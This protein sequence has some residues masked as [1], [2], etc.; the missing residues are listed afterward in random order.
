MC[1]AGLSCFRQHLPGGM[2]PNATVQP[3]HERLLAKELWGKMKAGWIGQ[4]VVS[5][6]GLPQEP[7]WRGATVPEVRVSRREPS[8]VFVR[9]VGEEHL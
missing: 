9:A 4:I 3:K 1:A 6:W 2:V 7:G 8:I 5:A